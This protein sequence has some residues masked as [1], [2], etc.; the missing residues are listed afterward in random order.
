MSFQN[1]LS[2]EVRSFTLLELVRKKDRLVH[3]GGIEPV[4]ANYDLYAGWFSTKIV[5]RHPDLE[6]C[7]ESLPLSKHLSVKPEQISPKDRLAVNS[8]DA[9]A[10]STLIR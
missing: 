5:G 4:M 3:L 9:A 8:I 1:Q 10:I 2:H 6:M 7:S